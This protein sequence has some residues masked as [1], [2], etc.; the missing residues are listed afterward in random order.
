MTARTM[1][2]VVMLATSFVLGVTDALSAPYPVKPLRLIVPFP[3]GGGLD[4]VARI[5]AKEMSEGL[6]QQIVIDNRP[7]AGGRLGTDLAAKASPDGYTLLLGS[8]GPLAFAPT[9]YKTLPY[10]PAKDFS[11][12]S[13][14][15]SLPN[16]L[17][18]NSSSSMTSVKDIVARAIANPDKL[19]YASAGA[20]TPPHLAM[21]LF[22]STAK[23]KLVHVPYKGGPPALNDLLGGQVD[24]M[25]INILTALPH[26]NSG[27][28]K[29]LAVSTTHRVHI[30]PTVPTMEDAGDLSGFAA[31][32]WFGLLLPAGVPTDIVHRLNAEVVRTIMSREVSSKL[33]NQG[34]EPVTTSPEEFTHYI[35]AEIAKW[36]QVINKAAIKAN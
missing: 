1:L 29:A 36:R 17:L 13:L 26:V 32:D 24:L 34:A 6:K 35:K 22:K 10:D 25:F 5:V 20:G 23:I 31:N 4:I 16:V 15:A 2:C 19:N 30:L 28:L 12:V 14:M 7:G 3:P 9:L 18:V 33:T 21:E 27:K 8:V 11:P